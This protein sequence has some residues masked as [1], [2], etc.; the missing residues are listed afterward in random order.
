MRS[1]L[2]NL[3]S[4]G[5]LPGPYPIQRSAGRLVI[6]EPS[7]TPANASFAPLLVR[8]GFNI[9]PVAA[10]FPGT[11]PYD[12]YCPS[13]S[14]KLNGKH[15]NGYFLRKLFQFQLQLYFRSDMPGLWHVLLKRGQL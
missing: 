14:G 8:L 11:P 12:L 7:D 5:Y 2:R 9:K 3:L 6:P 15:L 10:G 13:L 4:D 1:D